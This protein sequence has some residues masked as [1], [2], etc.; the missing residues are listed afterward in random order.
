MTEQVDLAFACAAV[1]AC[2]DLLAIVTCSIVCAR[3]TSSIGPEAV[4]MLLL[5]CA[6]WQHA[7]TSF[8]VLQSAYQVK[9]WLAAINA[10]APLHCSPSDAC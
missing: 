7:M 9:E 10:R 3:T 1:A 6:C 5:A 4:D 2:V 8:V